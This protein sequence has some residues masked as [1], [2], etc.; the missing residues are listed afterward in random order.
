MQVKELS[1]HQPSTWMES[2]WNQC[3]RCTDLLIHLTRIYSENISMSFREIVVMVIKRMKVI[4][5]AD[6][7]PL[8]VG[9]Y[10]RPI[11]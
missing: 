8:V 3:E 5:V 7:V 11:G 6:D 10:S 2:R 9:R 4:I 1:Y